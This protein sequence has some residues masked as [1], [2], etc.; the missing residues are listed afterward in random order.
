MVE[1]SPCHKP[2]AEGEN[3]TWEMSVV[4]LSDYLSSLC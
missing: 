4:P 2:F 1:C 3:K